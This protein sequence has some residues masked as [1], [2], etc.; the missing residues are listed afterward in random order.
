MVSRM[1]DHFVLLVD[2]LL[3]E[4]TLETAIQSKIRLQQTSP[5]PPVCVKTSFSFHKMDAN[6]GSSPR[7]LGECRI[8]HDEDEESNM[9]SPCFCRGSLK[10]SLVD[11]EYMMLNSLTCS[12]VILASNFIN[13]C[14][15]PGFLI[16]F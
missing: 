1:R 2:Q 8:C 9:E 6:L 14:H 5:S 16:C 15:Y 3:T 12:R 7:K 10:V 4:S 11:F 13:H